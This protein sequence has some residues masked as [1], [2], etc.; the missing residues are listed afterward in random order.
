MKTLLWILIFLIIYCYAGYPLLINLLSK[1]FPKPVRKADI[2]PSVS[3]VI[4][5]HNEEDVISAK[6]ASL[7]ALDYPADQ[8]EILI[9]SDCSTDQ[10]NHIIETCTDPR[11]RLFAYA[12]RRGK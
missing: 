6:L 5:A 9:G 10:T 12:K 11:V 3:I 2:Y 4:A 7:R 8:I 1:F